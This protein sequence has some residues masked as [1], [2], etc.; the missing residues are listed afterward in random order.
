MCASLPPLKGEVA[1]QGRRGSGFSFRKAAAE[2]GITNL[3][4]HKTR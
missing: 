3:G 4:M 1:R 2:S